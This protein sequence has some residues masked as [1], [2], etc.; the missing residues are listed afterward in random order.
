M[1][2]DEQISQ[3]FH[4]VEHHRRVVDESSGFSGRQYFTAQNGEFGLIVEIVFFKKKPQVLL[5]DVENT[6]Y[7]AFLIFIFNGLLIGTLAQDKREGSQNNGFPRTCFAG[8]HR[9]ASFERSFELVDE[10]IIF[11]GNLF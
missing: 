3:R 4:L 11:Y 6:F 10:R 8:K 5:A 2:V 9:K 7:Y 1:D